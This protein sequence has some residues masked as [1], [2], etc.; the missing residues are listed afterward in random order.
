M[1]ISEEAKK[2][3]LPWTTHALTLASRAHTGFEQ[4]AFDKKHLVKNYRYALH[5]Y[6][7][8]N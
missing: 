2:N 7:F 1:N 5:L 3:P 8:M 4:E 6:L